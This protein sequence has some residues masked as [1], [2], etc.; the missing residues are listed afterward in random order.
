MFGR[1]TID[2][3]ILRVATATWGDRN[4][5][6]YALELPFG[7]L[8]TNTLSQV[9]AKYGVTNAGPE[10]WFIDDYKVWPHFES[11]TNKI[12]EIYIWRTTNTNHTPEDTAR[13]LADP[14]H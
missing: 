1:N 3:I 9:I 7:L 12:S 5:T 4:W 10:T 6:S 14:Q 8:A 11:G 2:C 13:K